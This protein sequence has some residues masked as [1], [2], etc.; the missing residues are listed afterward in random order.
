MQRVVGGRRDVGGGCNK[1]RSHSSAALTLYF[2][3][4]IIVIFF[5]FR[6]IMFSFD[7][8]FTP[9]NCDWI[10]IH[11]GLVIVGE[12]DFRRLD[13]PLSKEELR[14]LEAPFDTTLH[15]ALETAKKRILPFLRDE[16]KQMAG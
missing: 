6:L 10:K 7:I 14:A 5:L 2:S 15:D 1:F 8:I 13:L 9:H 11:G 12:Q 4:H 3:H 16:R